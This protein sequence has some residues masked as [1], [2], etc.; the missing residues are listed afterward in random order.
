MRRSSCIFFDIRINLI[1]VSR[2]YLIAALMWVLR[3]KFKI[4]YFNEPLQGTSENRMFTE[5][6]FEQGDSCTGA[7][8]SFFRAHKIWYHRVK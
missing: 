8:S 7:V 3:I 5:L 1:V 6:N 2:H 4:I